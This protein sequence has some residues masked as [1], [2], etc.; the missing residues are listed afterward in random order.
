MAEV[1]RVRVSPRPPNIKMILVVHMT[2][3]FDGTS[4]ISNQ[5]LNLIK[6]SNEETFALATKDPGHRKFGKFILSAAGEFDM[7][8]G[9]KDVTVCGLYFK[10]CMATTIQLVS[11]TARS[12]R[13]PTTCIASGSN[14]T[15]EDQRTQNH[16][17]RFL[18]DYISPFLVDIVERPFS[19]K[20]VGKIV[21][22]KFA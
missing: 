3:G 13:L 14:R 8:I 22:V 17:K 16:Q 2:D 12:I 11:T 10:A 15:L 6:W 21:I 4:L 20:M 1:S 18:S 5:I 7:D 9:Y 19:L